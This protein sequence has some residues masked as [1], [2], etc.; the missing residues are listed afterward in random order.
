MYYIKN[1]SSIDIFGVF[2]EIHSCILKDLGMTPTALAGLGQSLMSFLLILVE[3]GDLLLLD[4]LDST[5]GPSDNL[6][7]S[8][9]R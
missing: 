6:S 8:S 5:S 1:V 2:S 3:V 4:Q 7:D 9:K